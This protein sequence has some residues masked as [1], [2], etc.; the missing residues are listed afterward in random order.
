MIPITEGSSEPNGFVAIAISDP[1]PKA[2]SSF[3]TEIIATA[4]SKAKTPLQMV[5][6]A[7]FVPILP[8]PKFKLPKLDYIPDG[9]ISLI[10]FIRL[11]V[12]EL[13]QHPRTLLKLLKDTLRWET[14]APP[15][16]LGQDT[17]AT[18]TGAYRSEAALTDSMVPKGAITVT[19]VSTAGSSA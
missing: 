7:G 17:V 18:G 10:R 8:S 19:S 12:S 4:A 11:R 9:T 16:G 14:P 13:E 6:E 2:S 1:S 15:S 5:Q 3:T